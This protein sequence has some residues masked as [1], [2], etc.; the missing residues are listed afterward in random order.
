MFLNLK[1]LKI[2]QKGKK[3]LNSEYKKKFLNKPKS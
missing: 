1:T 2:L 3:V